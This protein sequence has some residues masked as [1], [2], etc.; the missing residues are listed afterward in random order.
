[1]VARLERLNLSYSRMNPRVS[2]HGTPQHRGTMG[3]HEVLT[4]N[5]PPTVAF[6][7]SRTIFSARVG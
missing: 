7:F 6:G 3:V 1:M 5:L 2:P 4:C